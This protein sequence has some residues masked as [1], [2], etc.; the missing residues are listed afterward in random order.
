VTLRAINRQWPDAGLWGSELSDASIPTLHTIPNFRGLYTCPPTEIDERFDLV[1]LVHSLEHLIAPIDIL[2]QLGKLLNPDGQIFVQVPNAAENPF[3]L[4]VADHMSHFSPETLAGALDAAG[5]L[6]GPIRTD[7]VAKELTY[8]SNVRPVG[9]TRAGERG[10]QK[11]KADANLIWLRHQLEAAKTVV[12][13]GRRLGIFGS[14][15]AATWLL[16]GLGDSIDFFVDEDPARIGRKMEGRP[17]LSVAEVP[18]DATVFVPLIPRIA[19]TVV[20]RL[21]R[22]GVICQA[23]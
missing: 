20:A 2:R 22:H 23:A 3:D 19:E 14:S 17:I 10:D 5:L 13:S 11:V 15:I 1:V 9:L 4:V 8:L 18:S 12:A 7:V 16:S 21:Q 6:S